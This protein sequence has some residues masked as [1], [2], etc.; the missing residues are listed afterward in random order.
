MLTP[1]VLALA[2]SKAVLE[3]VLERRMADVNEVDGTLEIGSQTRIS[4]KSPTWHMYLG[5]E[6]ALELFVP[7]AIV[8]MLDGVAIVGLSSKEIVRL[9]KGCGFDNIA[10]F[11]TL[12]ATKSDAVEEF[13]DTTPTTLFWPLEPALES[14]PICLKTA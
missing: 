5:L 13:P 6:F 7:V 2:E 12:L 14:C 3:L 9:V 8:G 1:F 4:I 11:L 10:S